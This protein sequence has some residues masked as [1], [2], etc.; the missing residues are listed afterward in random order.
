METGVQN[1]SLGSE[2]NNKKTHPRA[3]HLRS[4]NRS[5]IAHVSSL[6]WSFPPCALRHEPGLKHRLGKASPAAERRG[7]CQRRLPGIEGLG[8]KKA[9]RISFYNHKVILKLLQENLSLNSSSPSIH[10][11]IHSPT[12]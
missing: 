7:E 1:K 8:N 4:R 11:F 12:V 6:W 5:P 2:I 10:A 9:R 3:R